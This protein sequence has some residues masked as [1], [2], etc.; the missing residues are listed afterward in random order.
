MRAVSEGE[1]L[2]PSSVAPEAP[3]PTE[4][5]GE[6]DTDGTVLVGRGAP[7]L[8]MPASESFDELKPVL[9]QKVEEARSMRMSSGP[10]R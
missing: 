4:T 6:A 3:A 8:G 2:R 7:F 9:R 10:G 1:M 5:E